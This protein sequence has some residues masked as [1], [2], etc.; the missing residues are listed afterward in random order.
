MQAGAF[1]KAIDTVMAMPGDWHKRLNMAQ[2][3]VRCHW[4]TLIGPLV[5]KEFMGWKSI[6]PE[7]RNCYYQASRLIKMANEELY[8]VLMN[9]FVQENWSKYGAIF[10]DKS[11]SDVNV[12]SQLADK[13]QFYL[14]EHEKETA[15]GDEFMLYACIFF[16]HVQ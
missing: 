1:C 2:S 5:S 8:C 13:Y 4:K 11:S 3:I 14:Q 15:G 6:N 7:V 16:A 12:L 10:C 9:K